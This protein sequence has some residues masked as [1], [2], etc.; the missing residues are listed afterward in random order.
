MNI[1]SKAFCFYWGKKTIYFKYTIK[2]FVIIKC[3]TLAEVSP[4]LKS[5]SLKSEKKFFSH[6]NKKKWND[7]REHVVAFVPTGKSGKSLDGGLYK[8]SLAQN[9]GKRIQSFLR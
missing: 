2:L 6:E 3:F 7:E 9:I 8:V 4:T 5:S 1:Y